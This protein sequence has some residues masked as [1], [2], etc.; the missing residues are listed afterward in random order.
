MLSIA[1]WNWKKEEKK[2]NHSQFTE[3]WN[4]KS[5]EL[6]GHLH[7]PKLSPFITVLVMRRSLKGATPIGLRKSLAGL[8]NRLDPIMV[9]LGSLGGSTVTTALT[10]GMDRHVSSPKHLTHTNTEGRRRGY[11]KRQQQCYCLT[12]YLSWFREEKCFCLL[13]KSYICW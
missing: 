13:T 4:D 10:S 5:P 6:S 2:E 11:R 9:I 7:P 8:M 3:S 1:N 12:S